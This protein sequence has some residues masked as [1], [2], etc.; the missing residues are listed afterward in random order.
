ML[1]YQGTFFLLSGSVCGALAVIMG[2]IGAHVIAIPDKG[3]SSWDLAVFYQLSHS[4]VL[5]LV[6][7]LYKQGY[8]SVWI[9]IAGYCFFGGML[10]FCGGI[11][12]G[13]SPLFSEI[14]FVTP[15]GG[16]LLVLG[17]VSLVGGTASK[18]F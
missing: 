4:G 15:L 14:V 13:Q 7:I 18:L 1:L 10:F 16:S 3:I 11:Y 8:S 17:W 12:I 2:A 9:T 5:L 6:G